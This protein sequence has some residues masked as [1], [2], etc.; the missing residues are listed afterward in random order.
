MQSV[1]IIICWLTPYGATGYDA[2]GWPSATITNQ[3]L[4]SGIVKGAD[5]N[6]LAGVTVTLTVGDKTYTANTDAEGKYKFDTMLAN[7]TSYTLTATKVTD[8]KSKLGTVNE[9]NIN[10]NANWIINTEPSDVTM[11][12]GDTGKSL[13][14][15]TSDSTY[16]TTFQWCQ[17]SEDNNETI[18]DINNATSTTYT[19]SDLSVGTYKYL[20]KVTRNGYTVN[21]N[22]ATVTVNQKTGSLTVNSENKY[23]T[24][25]IY[26][27]SPIAAPVGNNFIF[28]DPAATFS[29]TWYKGDF[30]NHETLNDSDKL[31]FTE[32]VTTPTD[33]GDYTLVATTEGTTNA[34]GAELR[35]KVEISVKTSTVSDVTYIEPTNLTY[36]GTGKAATV[37]S[38]DGV[39][40]LGTIKVWYQKEGTEGYSDVAPVNVGTY[41]V[42][43]TIEAGTNYSV[44]A[45]KTSIDQSFTI[46]KA[47]NTPN[48]PDTTLAPAY[49]CDTVSKASLPTGWIWESEDATKELQ[50]GVPVTVIAIYN[51]ADKGNY[52]NESVEITVTRSTC[53]HT[54]TE[55]RNKKAAT[56]TKDG[57][58]GDTYCNNCGEK[59]STGKSIKALGHTW[60]AWKVTKKAT[61][62]ATG[63]ETRVCSVCGTKQTRVI[64]KI[65]VYKITYVLNKG[66]NNK[67]NPA[68]RVAEK[69]VTLKNPTRKGY[70]FKGWYQDSKFKNKITSIKKGSKKN[71]TVYAKWEKISVKKAATP[72]LTNSRTR[73]MIVRYGRTSGAKGYQI[74]YATN[75]RFTKGKVVKTTTG[76]TVTFKRLKKNTTYYVRVRAYKVDSTGRKVYGKYS[77]VKKIKIKK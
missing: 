37:T 50:V 65:P 18:T 55:V 21:S 25:Y 73:K 34:S 39:I 56:C 61:T 77:T 72:K 36:D 23:K 13:T 1:G 31:T 6:P 52:E 66:T 58:T 4:V 41:H 22:I 12:Y 5:T 64:A 24:S 60:G 75:S 48:K 28:D 27:G 43:I 17:V 74:T 20:V 38:K 32:G 8:T 29:F 40:G 68:K 15:S 69:T 57:Y 11:T 42:F 2:S 62:T 10:W 16:S 76:R 46:A 71:Y 19:L 49:S 45:E 59:I 3:A 14:V 26:T 7:G 67:Y 54:D 9:A 70:V 33:V 63:V 51:G 44:L 35:T 47:I 30:T 53:K